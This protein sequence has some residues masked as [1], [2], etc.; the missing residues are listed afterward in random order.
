MMHWRPCDGQRCVDVEEAEP[1]VDSE[2]PWQT[3]ISEGLEETMMLLSSHVIVHF[4]RWRERKLSQYKKK[5]SIRMT[6]TLT[7]VR[8]IIAKDLPI[9]ILQDQP[10]WSD[11]L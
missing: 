8:N 5:N 9:E 1:R 4:H 6:H 3:V 2:M 7:V 11:L 10:T